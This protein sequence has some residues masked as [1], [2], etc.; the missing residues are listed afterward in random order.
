MAPLIEPLNLVG[1]LFPQRVGN[2]YLHQLILINDGIYLND[3]C[4][5]L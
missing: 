1:Y 3:F 4:N 2:G 5:R